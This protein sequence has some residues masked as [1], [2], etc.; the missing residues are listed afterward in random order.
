MS[1]DAASEPARSF[2]VICVTALPPGAN[3]LPVT[4]TSVPGL[5]SAKSDPATMP[6]SPGLAYSSA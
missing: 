5:K 6:D 3:A 1:S 4:I 2:T